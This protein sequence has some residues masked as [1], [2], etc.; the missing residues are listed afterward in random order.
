MMC[1]THEIRIQ[2][3]N[4]TQHNTTQH[5]DQDRLNPGSLSRSSAAVCARR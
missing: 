3:H 4:V 2:T 5:H 1:N